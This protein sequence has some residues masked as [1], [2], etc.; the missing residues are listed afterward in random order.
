M[1]GSRRPAIGLAALTVALLALWWQF[2]YARVA[3]GRPAPEIVAEKWINSEGLKLRELRGKVVLVE[4]WTFGCYNCRNVEPH[5]QEWY[6]KYSR[7][8]FLVIGVHSPE[9]SY[10]R[11]LANLTHYVQSHGIS[12]PIAIDNDF[13]VWNGYGNDA[14]PALYLVDKHGLIRLQRVGEGGYPETETVIRDLLQEN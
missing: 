13:T 3:I 5:V 4:F 12:Y 10:E 9:Q 8:G 1:M 14:W 7:E 6:R 11:D 2:A